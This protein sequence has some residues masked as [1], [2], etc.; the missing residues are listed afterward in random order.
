MYKCDICDK[1]FAKEVQLKSHFHPMSCSC[2]PFDTMRCKYC[3]ENVSHKYQSVPCN[4][5]CGFGTDVDCLVEHY[6]IV[7]P[8][9]I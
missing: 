7:T 8:L 4:G 3:V 9:D 1:R 2:K 5:R 6:E